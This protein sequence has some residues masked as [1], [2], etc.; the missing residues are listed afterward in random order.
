MNR[1]PKHLLNHFKTCSL[2]LSIILVFC[3][4]KVQID[5]EVKCQEYPSGTSNP[6]IDKLADTKMLPFL[7]I[8][9]LDIYYCYSLSQ[10]NPKL[11]IAIL[12]LYGEYFYETEKLP[13]A[14]K[15]LTNAVNLAKKH[16]EDEH[17]LNALHI[18]A[19]T[20][21]NLRNRDFAIHLHKEYLNKA[22]EIGFDYEV[23][24][25]NAALGKI[26]FSQEKYELALTHFSKS[27]EI[28]QKI[29][30]EHPKQALNTST[31]YR[32]TNM[33]LGKTY[34]ELGQKNKA[35]YHV[36][37]SYE[38]IGDYH[39]THFNFLEVL[40]GCGEFYLNNNN[41]IKAKEIIDKI[42]V[43]ISDKQN[44]IQSRYTSNFFNLRGDYYLKMNNTK[45]AVQDKK[46]AFEIAAENDLFDGLMK[47]A[48]FLTEFYAESSPSKRDYYLKVTNEFL[49]KL[50]NTNKGIIDLENFSNNLQ[51]ESDKVKMLIQE[52]DFLLAKDQ[53]RFNIIMILSISLLILCLVLYF[54]L[55]YYST[56][57]KHKKGLDIAKKKLDKAYQNLKT[58]NIKLERSNKDLYNFAATAAHDLK[59]PLRTI[60]FFSKDLYSKLKSNLSID[61]TESFDLIISSSQKMTSQIEALL[62]FSRVTV[63]LPPAE[64]IELKKLIE[65]LI[66]FLGIENKTNHVPLI[67]IDKNLGVIHGHRS[68]FEKLFSNLLTNSIYFCPVDKRPVIHVSKVEET[69]EHIMFCIEDN[70]IGIP[71]KYL[72]SVFTIFRKF[73]SPDVPQNEGSGLGLAICQR[74]IEF[75]NGKIW[76]KSEYGS[77]T[78]MFFTLSKKKSNIGN[79]KDIPSSATAS[80]QV[81]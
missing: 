54:L 46:M 58:T 37:S 20:Y 74:I 39:N 77:G 66:L 65:D 47:P 33:L 64:N 17:Y 14:K 56:S 13:K 69:D 7:S 78:Q 24:T 52:K 62:S 3:S 27:L 5:R 22:E 75:Y 59:A 31:N 40:L 36:R 68:L 26:L 8:D 21:L 15:Y 23:A 12:R 81:T 6:N 49:T 16:N 72:K 41:L 34:Y 71:E 57:V 50:I 44:F 67:T 19:H 48:N 32:L 2:L 60:N 61:D 51:V 73:W 28:Y 4:F 79:R 11:D 76:A 9:T 55:K 10:N 29:T 53:S 45:A 18:L 35:Y 30:L 1:R 80:R 70:G 38:G 42:E 43:D 63:N 25:G